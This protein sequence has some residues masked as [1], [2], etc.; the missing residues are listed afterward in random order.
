MFSIDLWFH[1]YCNK[2]LVS[3]FVLNKNLEFGL[4]VDYVV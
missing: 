3:L 4:V 2:I 1:K